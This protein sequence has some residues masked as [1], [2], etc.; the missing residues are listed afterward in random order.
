[1]IPVFE[2]SEN[3]TPDECEAV[4]QTL[5]AEAS[6]RLQPFSASTTIE[7]LLL[8]SIAASTLAVAKKTK[9]VSRAR[10]APTAG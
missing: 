3:W 8:A 10:K 9:G 6:D 4:A 5:L 1:M 7:T 2:D